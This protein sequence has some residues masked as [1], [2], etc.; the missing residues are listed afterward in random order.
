MRISAAVAAVVVLQAVCLTAAPVSQPQDALEQEPSG[1]KRI[2][3]N[4]IGDNEGTGKTPDSQIIVAQQQQ[5][6]CE[7]EEGLQNQQQQQELVL[8]QQSHET[9]DKQRPEQPEQS[10]PSPQ[11]PLQ[12]QEQQED[13]QQQQ[14]TQKTLVDREKLTETLRA[15]WDRIPQAMNEEKLRQL[16]RRLEALITPSWFSLP[17][18]PNFEAIPGP[19]AHV[20]AHLAVMEAWAKEFFPNSKLANAPAKM[21]RVYWQTLQNSSNRLVANSRGST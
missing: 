9:P 13:Q 18:V 20:E 15:A 6:Q 2:T 12:Q 5:E 3:S 10:S 7:D 8:E 21:A 4:V 17:F 14:P 11:V 19:Q 1:S 16:A